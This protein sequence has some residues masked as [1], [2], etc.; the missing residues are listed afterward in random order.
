MARRYGKPFYG[1]KY[2]GIQGVF[3]VHDMDFECSKCKIDEMIEKYKVIPFTPDN[4]DQAYVEGYDKCG[5]CLGGG[6]TY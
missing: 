5:W 2:L 3:V 4:I 1:S 6:K